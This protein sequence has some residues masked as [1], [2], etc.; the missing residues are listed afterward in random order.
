MSVGTVVS[1]DSQPLL[2]GK[3]LNVAKD[4]ASFG[5]NRHCRQEERSIAA[6][7]HDCSSHHDKS[8]SAHVTARGARRPGA[9]SLDRRWGRCS[10]S[11]PRRASERATRGGAS[12]ARRSERPCPNAARSGRSSRE[13]G[14]TGRPAGRRP[15]W[16]GRRYEGREGEARGGSR[17]RHAPRDPCKARVRLAA[18]PSDP[19]E[20]GSATSER[21]P[22]G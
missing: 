10:R 12:D 7:G 2:K 11:A 20:G 16:A 17:R 14:S 19:S 5:R 9:A 18:D 6:V 4:A 21:H 1:I 22:P 8:C 13:T 15:R 3:P